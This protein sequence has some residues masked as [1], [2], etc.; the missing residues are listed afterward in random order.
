MA[1][2]R[3]ARDCFSLFYALKHTNFALNY[4]QLYTIFLRKYINGVFDMGLCHLKSLENRQL[5]K[6]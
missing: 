2:K 4:I 1:G 3:G 6:V 5:K